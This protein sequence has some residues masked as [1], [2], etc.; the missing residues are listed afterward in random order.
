MDEQKKKDTK[1]QFLHICSSLI[2]K[3]DPLMASIYTA[4]SAHSLDLQ[5]ANNYIQTC[6]I[7]HLS[8]TQDANSDDGVTYRSLQ[9]IH[10]WSEQRNGQIDTAVAESPT[11][12]TEEQGVTLA[13]SHSLTS[14]PQMIT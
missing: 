10:L 4:R 13:A 9:N 3:T 1:H 6:R 5:P 14:G 7:K 11:S 8:Q 12:R 2:Q